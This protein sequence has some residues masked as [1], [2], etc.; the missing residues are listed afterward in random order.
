M[1]P[2]L[3]VDTHPL[4]SKRLEEPGCKYDIRRLGT[5]SVIGLVCKMKKEAYT[6]K[7]KWPSSFQQKIGEGLDT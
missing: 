2:K 5:C 7:Y 6:V 3:F 4:R 1:L